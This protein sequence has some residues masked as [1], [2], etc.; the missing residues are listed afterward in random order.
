MK[1]NVLIPSFNHAK[2]IESALRSVFYQTLAPSKL[3][4]IDDGS[5][6][7]SR[8]IIEKVLQDCPFQASFIRRENRG[9]TRTLNEGF[10]MLA[11]S[12]FFA[13]LGS[14]DV[15]FPEFL[16]RRV[17]LLVKNPEASLVFG[18]VFIIDEEDNIIDSTADWFDFDSDK[19][20]DH[21]LRGE[22]FSSPSVVYRT[23]YLKK[24]G[25]NEDAILEDYE[26]YLKLALE[27]N[28]VFDPTILS[29]WRQHDQN[30]SRNFPKMMQEWFHAQDRVLRGI[31]SC[32][33][34]TKIQKRLRFKSVADLVRFG[35]KIEAFKLFFENISGAE[36]FRQVLNM[37]LRLTI[38]QKLFQ[39]NRRRKMRSKIRKYGNLADLLSKAYQQLHILNGFLII[40]TLLI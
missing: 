25:W 7:E 19:M 14:D 35:Y 39:A 32:E 12:D 15:W 30:T 3:L 9:L 4:V 22:I 40:S 17:S 31:F 38:P 27:S 24:H 26:L 20:L 21:L 18:H 29:A 23:E 5:T 37:A 33:E 13:Y 36:N 10:A 1:V 34:L 2:F 6:D 16:E 11:D 8:I 28:F